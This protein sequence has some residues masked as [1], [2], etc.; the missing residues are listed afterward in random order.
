MSEKYL[1]IIAA[2]LFVSIV[3]IQLI[4]APTAP[5]PT[6]MTSSM[7]VV[8]TAKTPNTVTQVSVNVINTLAE[9]RVVVP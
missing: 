9:S 3:A 2:I 1:L 6:P 4:P 8:S 7:G 5:E